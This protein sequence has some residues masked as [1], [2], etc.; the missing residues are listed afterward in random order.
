MQIAGGVLDIKY[1]DVAV[2]FQ[3]QAYSFN[4]KADAQIWSDVK[5]T[6]VN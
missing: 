3:R 1:E 2:S 5:H 4:F 6:S